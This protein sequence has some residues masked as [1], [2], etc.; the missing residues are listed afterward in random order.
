MSSTAPTRTTSKTLIITAI[1]VAIGAL[2]AWAAGANGYS[3]GAVPAVLIAAG[4]AFA[5]QWVAFI[6]SWLLRSER[7]YDLVGGSTYLVISLALLLG[8]ADRG[9]AATVVAA[10]VSVWSVRLALFLFARVRAT[11]GDGRFDGITTR[12]LR[13]LQTWTMQGLWVSVTASAAWVVI[14]DPSGRG[15]DAWLIAGAAIWLLGF[16]IEATADEQKRAFRRRGGDGFITSGVWAA[17]RHPNY[18]GEILVWIGVGVAAVPSLHGWGWVALV[19]PLFVAPLLTRVSGVPLLERR[20][21]QRWGER[22]DYRGYVDRTPI[23]V[24]FIGR[25]GR[26]ARGGAES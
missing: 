19:S 25:R 7:F 3:I 5:V 24:P 21:E 16:G 6:P 2:V 26:W 14:A 11:G 20:A 10:L 15:V 23:L 1:A 4:A 8:N 12:P 17:S 18:F 9:P 13:L 22:A